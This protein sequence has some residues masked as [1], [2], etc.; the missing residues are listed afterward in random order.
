[1]QYRF[2]KYA[3]GSYIMLKTT[4][5]FAKYAIF[6]DRLARIFVEHWPL[7]VDICRML[8]RS[9]AIIL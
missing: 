9:G 1:M 6:D 2:K 7:G 5:N 8:H 3:V 4:H